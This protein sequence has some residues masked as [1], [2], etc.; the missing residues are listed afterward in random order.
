MRETPSSV[1]RR[2][3]RPGSDCEVVALSALNLN[4]LDATVRRCIAIV[5][6]SG[7]AGDRL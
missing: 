1:G 5:H 2:S 6:V 3:F 4:R 7:G